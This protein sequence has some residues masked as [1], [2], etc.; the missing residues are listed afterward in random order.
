MIRSTFRGEIAGVGGESGVRVVVGRWHTS[1]LGSFADV[2]VA[3]AE[4]RRILLAPN[5]EVAE[6]VGAT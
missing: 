1:P 5:D 3:T 6:F 4:G 2:M